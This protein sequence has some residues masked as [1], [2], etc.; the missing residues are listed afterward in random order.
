M[1]VRFKYQ[2]RG[3]EA[4]VEMEIISLNP[5]EFKILFHDGHPDGELTR[6]EM[7]ALCREAA[8]KTRH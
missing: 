8:R 2:L 6:E 5:V 4:D 1:A 3:K 7:V